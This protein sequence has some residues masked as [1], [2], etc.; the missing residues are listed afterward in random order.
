[1]SSEYFIEPP[2]G[3][4]SGEKSPPVASVQYKL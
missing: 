4:V 3:R 2:A 1:M